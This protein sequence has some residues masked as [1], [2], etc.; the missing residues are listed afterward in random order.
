MATDSYP[1]D[2]RG[3]P[4]QPYPY[5]QAPAPA[6]YGGGTTRGNPIGIVSFIAGMLLVLWPFVAV[7]VQSGIAATGDFSGFEVFAWLD[8]GVGILLGLVAVIAGIIAV[9]LPDRP[10]VLGAMGLGIGIL[11]IAGVIAY[12]LIYPLLTRFA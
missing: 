3:I 2:A 12:S 7:I 4:P 9:V 10:R 1:P 8:G 6:P 11:A 5:A